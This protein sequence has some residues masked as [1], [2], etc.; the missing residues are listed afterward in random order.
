M[1]ETKYLMGREVT[2]YEDGQIT[3]SKQNYTHFTGGAL[4]VAREFGYMYDW[5][6]V[7]LQAIARGL[8]ENAV[9][10][11]L[12]AGV[13][14]SGLAMAEAR[15]EL[16]HNIYTIDVVRNGGFS[17]GL[18]AEQNIFQRYNTPL[19]NQIEGDSYEV[20]MNWSRGPVDIV[21]VDG[22]HTGYGV[23]RDIK[24]WLPRVKNGG[25]ILFHDYGHQQWGNIKPVVDALMGA[26]EQLMVVDLLAVYR[27]HWSAVPA[28]PI[29]VEEAKQSIELP[30][31]TRKPRVKVA[32]EE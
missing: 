29:P 3:I 1:P 25:F 31:K 22:D 24:A 12:G 8:P 30:K 11:N 10:V 14:T 19:V 2:V 5:E 21:F 16:I 17:S 20:G 15:M 13:G 9:L 6:V 18:V 32:Q 7:V 4:K 27:V 26:H 28:E 23:E